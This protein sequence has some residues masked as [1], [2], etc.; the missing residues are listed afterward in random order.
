M[1][2]ISSGRMGCLRNVTP[3]REIEMYTVL[4]RQPEGKGDAWKIYI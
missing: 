1:K 3:I 2:V 4:V